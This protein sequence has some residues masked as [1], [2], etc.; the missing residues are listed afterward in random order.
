MQAP[1]DWDIVVRAERAFAEALASL[2]PRDLPELIG[3]ALRT[4]AERRAA[5]RVLR[6]SP[7]EL[8]TA[9]LA[10]LSGLLLVSHSLLEE[11]RRVVLRLEPDVLSAYLDG[12]VQQLMSDSGADYEAY[13]RLAELLVRARAARPLTEL[14]ASALASPD[15]DIREVAD[16]FVNDDGELG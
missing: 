7:P 12:L 16:D 10:D 6:D 4:L 15:S 13:R 5:L 1:S 11:C 2:N 3:P 14:M 9:V 8:T